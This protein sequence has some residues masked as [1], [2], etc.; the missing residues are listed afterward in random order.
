[1]KGALEVL[2]HHLDAEPSRAEIADE[3]LAQ[4]ERL[5]NLVRDL[6]TYARPRPLSRQPVELHHLL[7]RVVRMVR[8]TDGGSSL[9]WHRK[10]TGDVDKILGDPQQLEQV[11]LNL[12]QNAIQATE[13][14]DSL[15]ISTERRDK[16]IEIAFQDTGK[17]ISRS[18]M[19]R[20]FQPFF[21][22]RHRG[23][24]LGLAIVQK[25]VQRHGGDIRMASVE[26]EGTT[27]I[28]SLPGEKMD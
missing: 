9:T 18:D 17:G 12:L 14:G 6:L 20:I 10:Y 24:G 4:I 22:T 3:L 11:F 7:D 28:V 2:R 26:G 23:S 8:E 25:I 5:E 15:T 21:T 13:G 16:R 19:E 1:M 27:A